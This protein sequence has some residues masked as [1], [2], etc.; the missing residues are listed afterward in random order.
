MRLGGHARTYL[1]GSI[2]VPTPASL[3]AVEQDPRAARR[4]ELA[5]EAAAVRS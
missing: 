4:R 3:L 1:H 2:V 5:A